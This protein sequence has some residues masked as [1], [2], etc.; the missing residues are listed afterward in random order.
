MSLHTL[1]REDAKTERFLRCLFEQGWAVTP[2]PHRLAGGY[3]LRCRE[4][5][6]L[7]GIDVIRGDAC[8]AD[9]VISTMSVSEH[10]RGKGIGSRMLATVLA[11]AG[12]CGFADIRAV[13]V[14]QRSTTF[15]AKN[16]FT[17]LPEPNPSND[18]RFAADEGDAP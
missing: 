17:R 14:Q 1:T 2:G 8:G 3:Q 11:A 7:V 5:G 6:V 13:Q 16:G 10:A 18:F 4:G 15:W 9:L 12:E